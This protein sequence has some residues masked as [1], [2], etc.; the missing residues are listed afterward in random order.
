[1]SNF[2]EGTH[3]IKFIVDGEF[4]CNPNYPTTTDSIGHLNNILEI[5]SAD[6]QSEAPFSSR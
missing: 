2:S 6:I 4:K 1:M 5:V 3:L